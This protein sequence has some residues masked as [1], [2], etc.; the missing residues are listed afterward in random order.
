MAA[1]RHALFVGRSMRIEA[2]WRCLRLPGLH[3]PPRA[4]SILSGCVCQPWPW[5]LRRR[6]TRAQIFQ[7]PPMLANLQV[8]IPKQLDPKERELVEALKEMQGSKT[9]GE[10]SQR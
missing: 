3:L 7:N 2:F 8:R 4:V 10:S 1:V 5:L 6:G 9:T